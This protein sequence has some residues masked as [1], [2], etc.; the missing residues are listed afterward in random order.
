MSTRPLQPES[1]TGELLILPD[2]RLLIHHLTPELAEVLSAV[3]PSDV[4]MRLRA[5]SLSPAAP[6]HETLPGN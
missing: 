5:K 4:R 6:L 2:G 3:D 1:G